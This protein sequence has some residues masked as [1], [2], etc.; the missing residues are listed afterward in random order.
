MSSRPVHIDPEG[1]LSD[2]LVDVI[3]ALEVSIGDRLALLETTIVGKAQ[4]A[5]SVALLASI[6]LAT[7]AVSWVAA[8]VAI[9]AFVADRFGVVLAAVVVTVINVVVAVVSAL[10]ARAVVA[11]SRS[12]QPREVRH[13]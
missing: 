3:D 2:A 7:A 1:A 5:A 4:V 13:D 6:A 12:R 10:L 9:G 11:R 8:N